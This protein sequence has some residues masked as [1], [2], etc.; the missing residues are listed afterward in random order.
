ME[1][2]SVENVGDPVDH[3]FVEARTY[4][5]GRELRCRVCDHPNDVPWY[6]EIWRCSARRGEWRCNAVHSGSE[7][8]PLYL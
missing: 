4:P 3:G 2:F 1:P 8:D 5:A 7:L 6:R